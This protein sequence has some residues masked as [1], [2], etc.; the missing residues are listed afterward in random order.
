MMRIFLYTSLRMI[1]L[2]CLFLF[3][4]GCG[5]VPI[6]K[7]YLINYEPDPLTR[8]KSL[9]PYPYAIRIKE[10]SIEQAYNRPQIVYRK[11][12]FELQYYH[13]RVWAVKP[14]QMITDLVFKHLVTTSLVSHVVRRFDEGIK[15]DF[16]LS[17]N[18]EA[19]EEYDSEDIWWAHLSIRFKLTRLRDNRTLYTRSLDHRKQVLV[20]D[21]EFVVRELTHIMDYI[22][23]QAI[24]DID[25]V[26]ADEYGIGDNNIDNS[27]NKQNIDSFM[28][29]DSIE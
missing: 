10:F 28:T 25:N 21:P 20:Y 23:S 24:H 13:F 15:P 29:G 14:A 8:R 22:V 3:I 2:L 7:F 12:P 26:L 4:G 17:G 27:E 19:I 16:E 9:S 18:I 1:T 6:K 11:S 5:N